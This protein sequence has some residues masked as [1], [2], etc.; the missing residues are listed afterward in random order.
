MNIEELRKICLSLPSVTED[1]KWENHLC[2]N[3]GGKMFLICGLDQNPLTASFKVSE[4]DFVSFS[5]KEGFKPAPYLARYRWIFSSDTSLLTKKQWEVII[6]NSYDLIR[7]K[8]PKKILA[9][10]E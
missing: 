6:K 9:E 7:S 5:S 2:F 10:L 8:L 4:D 1:I 3:I